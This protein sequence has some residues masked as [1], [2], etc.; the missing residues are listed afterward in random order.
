MR[1]KPILVASAAVAIALPAIAQQVAQTQPAANQYPNGGLGATQPQPQSTQ[2]AAPSSFGPNP[3]AGADESAVEVV[4]QTNLQPAQPIQPPIEYPGWARRDPWVVGRLDPAAYG[5]G[6]DPWGGASGAFLSTLMRRMDTPIA[7]RWAHIAVRDALLARARAPAYVNPVDWVAERAW[8]LLRMGEAD[9]ARMLVDGVDTDRFTP[10]MLQVG[11]QTALANADASALCPLE[12]GIRKYDPAIRQ[13]VQ[14]MCAALAGDPDTASAQIDNARRYGRIGGV[15][16]ALAEKVIGA[17][18]SG[19]A[20]TIEWE[21]VDSLT[22]WRFGLSTA[23]GML[24]PARLVNA[25]S[26]QLRAFQARAPL[27]SPQ[28]R[29]DSAMIAA[30]MGVFSSQTLVDLY[31][32]IYDTTDP[33]DLPST[34]AWQLREAFVGKDEPTRLAAIRH[35]LGLGKEG[36]QKEAARALVARAAT[37]VTPDAKLAKDAG[38]LISAMLAAGYDRAAARWIPAV[39]GMDDA[40]GDRCWAMLALAAPDIANVGTG[41]LGGFIRRDKSAHKIRSAFLVAGLAGLGRISTDTANSLN[42]RYGLGLGLTTSWTRIIDAS[43]GRGQAGTV[44]VL[45]GTGFQTPNW[46]KVPSPHLY[47]AVAAL[48]RTG[49]DFTA[50]MIAAEALSRT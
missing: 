5:M 10:K 39:N 12:N 28:Q 2:S 25:A 8:L 27:L 11:V 37:L 35:M 47:H 23:T 32:G 46:D 34:D 17:A 42:R 33:S 3:S 14:A 29:L 30:G 38:D 9:A 16:L 19:R 15:D 31:S 20:A 4:T 6:D 22:G 7:S 48:K 49:Q 43:A 36:L 50:R 24:P 13:L 26:P 21:P 41:R 1:I 44:L 40:T 45:T 18:G